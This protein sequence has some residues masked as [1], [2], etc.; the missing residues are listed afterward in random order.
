MNS[1]AVAAWIE[2][3]GATPTPELIRRRWFHYRCGLMIIAMEDYF[4]QHEAGLLSDEQFSRGSAAFRERFKE[5]GLRA[6]WLK[7]RKTMIKAA[8]RNCALTDGLS[9]KEPGPVGDRRR[10]AR[11]RTRN[12]RARRSSSRDDLLSGLRILPARQSTGPE[13]RSPTNSRPNATEKP[14][15]GFQP[16]Y[17]TSR[18]CLR[19]HDPF[20]A[21]LMRRASR[22]P[23]PQS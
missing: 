21:I 2:G 9:A 12:Q 7:Q 15:S 3:N 18:N 22:G 10:S 1:D 19:G 17:R 5:P 14:R 8:P 4:Q 20:P 16:L 23:V 13:N 11:P 6:Y